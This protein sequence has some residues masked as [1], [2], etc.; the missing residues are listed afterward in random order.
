VLSFQKIVRRL[1]RRAIQPAA[2]EPGAAAVMLARAEPA[3]VLAEERYHVRQEISRNSDVAVEPGASGLIEVELPYDGDKYLT[4]TTLEDIHRW[5]AHHPLRTPSA[6]TEPAGLPLPEAQIGHLLVSDHQST[7]LADVTGRAGRTIAVPLKI[8]VRSVDLPDT[9]SLVADRYKFR[10]ELR[11]RPSRDKPRLVPVELEVEV[12]DPG[13][14]SVPQ[15]DPRHQLDVGQA[16]DLSQEYM[17][18]S[19]YLELKMRVKVTLPERKGVLPPEPV[20]RR[21][22]LSLPSHRTLA[23]SS[24]QVTLLGN[25]DDPTDPAPGG[26][27][28]VQQNPADA[29]IEWF[30]VPTSLSPHRKEDG[31]RLFWSPW[32]RARIHQPGELFS[33][34][35]LLIQADVEAAD[36][37]LSGVQVRLFDARGRRFRGTRNP[38]TVRSLVSTEAT[39]VLHD[40]FAKRTFTPQLSFYFDEVI[41][42]PP[43]VQ[44]IQSALT[45][46]RFEVERVRSRGESKMS[47]SLTLI[48]H[49]EARRGDDEDAIRL[50]LFVLGRQ[51]RT[52]RESRHRGGRRY[53]SKLDS[54][55]LT[56]VVFGEAPRDSSQLVHEV[57][58]LQ[59]GLRDRF[60]RM[61]A[62]R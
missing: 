31:P 48:A 50:H 3:S 62:Q 8:P 60:R 56:L 35:E 40:A 5:A 7:D 17:T 41:P 13:S 36:V 2:D 9:D 46:L 47:K 52:Q 6:G 39:V 19:S 38:L 11:Y 26:R 20:L 43:R 49:L 37:L 30:D 25:G 32:M 58:A 27:P 22:S 42:G 14:V 1:R 57:N 51:H 24:V 53:T 29:A 15:I 55:D 10:E 59:Q 33:E 18:F 23:L 44:D 34:A 21:M 28:I 61:K 45:D 16:I 4:R 54:G 12:T